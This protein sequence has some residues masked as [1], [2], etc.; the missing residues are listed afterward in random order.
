M[1]KIIITAAALLLCTGLFAQE[2]EINAA[3]A[4]F[5]S[6]N[7]TG[8]QAELDKV[9]QLIDGNTI[10]PNSKAKYY[11][12]AGQLALVNGASIEAAK[13]FGEL[14]KYENG[15]MYSIRNK[16]TKTTEYFFTLAEAEQKAASGNYNKPKEEKLKVN[17]GA[18]ILA[19]LTQKAESALSQANN[20]INSENN[21]LAGDK[22]LE[23]AYLVKAM[24]LDYGLFQYNAALSYHKAKENQKAF[25]I[26]KELI[27]SGYTGVSSSWTAIEVESGNEVS[28]PTKESAD[29]QQK[30]GLIKSLKEVKTPSVEKSLYAY[31]LDALADLKKYDEVVEKISE[32]Y[33]NDAEIQTLVAN[34][35]HFSG[36]ND[37]FLNKLLES[38]ELEPNNPVNFF[39]IGV[40]YMDNNEDEKALEYFNKAIKADPNY[41]NA[42]TNIALVLIKPEKEL[43]EII[44]ANLGGSAKEKELYKLNIDKRKALYVQAIPYLKKA[45]EL[46]KTNYEYAKTLRQAYQIAEMFDEEDAMREIENS[47]KN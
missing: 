38:A 34:V 32:K 9:A 28:F 45:F 7:L 36:K 21:K 20:A 4:A 2:N 30:L 19:D 26:Y 22:F 1:K 16:D 15:S 8:A 5:E 13:M 37:L 6:N 44:N 24:G 18:N 17:Y 41:K 47:L 40:I 14:S 31:T 46:D 33:A 42:Y 11:Y 35:Y 27:N 25:D 10:S 23:A 12:V 29:M 3:L 39:N 43:V